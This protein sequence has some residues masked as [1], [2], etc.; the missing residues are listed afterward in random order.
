LPI[1]PVFLTLII[2]IASISQAIENFKI[3]Q[4]DSDS[5]VS[6][7]WKFSTEVYFYYLPEEDFYTM[8]IISSDHG[9]LHLEARYNYEDSRSLS[10]FA[11]RTFSIGEKLQ[12][13]V[14]PMMGG[15]VGNTLGIIPA[16]EFDLAYWNL[17][18]YSEAEYVYDLQDDQNNYFYNWTELNCYPLD[19]LQ[20]G[21]TSQQ[22]REVE[23]DWSIENG[24]LTGVNHS[25]YSGVF[26]LFNPGRSDPFYIFSLDINF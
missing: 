16:L 19:W 21:V 9:Q 13:E 22:T 12:L 23:A 8:P 11:G 17:E 2:Y 26:Y 20:L 5:Q 6:A 14:I 24:I 25:D 7:F 4:T 1:R 18:F 15:V 3:N 10:F